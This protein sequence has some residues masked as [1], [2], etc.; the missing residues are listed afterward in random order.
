MKGLSGI[1]WRGNW[2]INYVLEGFVVLRKQVEGY[3][4]LPNRCPLLG[5][6]Y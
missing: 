2:E 5:R 6:S 4:I 3:M 1:N